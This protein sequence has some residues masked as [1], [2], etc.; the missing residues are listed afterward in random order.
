MTPPSK[1]GKLPTNGAFIQK[2]KLSQHLVEK[3]ICCISLLL[4][5]LPVSQDIIVSYCGDIIQKL[6]HTCQNILYLAAY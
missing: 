3:V 2:E 4:F 6:A 1:M 5:G